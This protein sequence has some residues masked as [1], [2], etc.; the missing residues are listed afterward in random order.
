MISSQGR[1][2]SNFP[3]LATIPDGATLDFVS[4]S[5]NYKIT[6]ANFIT[7]MGATGSLVADGSSTRIDILQASGS[8][9]TIRGLESGNGITVSVGAENGANIAVNMTQEGSFTALVDTFATASPTFASLKGG[10]GISIS[11]AS[12]IITISA[13]GAKPHGLLTMSGNTTATTISVAGTPVLTAGTWTAGSTDN[14]TASTGGRLTYTGAETLDMTIDASITFR[15]ASANEVD[16][17]VTL[18]KN[19]SAASTSKRITS[20]SGS[21]QGSVSMP[22]HIEMAQ[23]DYLELFVSNEDTTDNLTVTSAMFRATR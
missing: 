16:A 1:K 15:S 9:Y 10:T 19:G 5:T 12:N 14:F 13:T 22:Y 2:K 7:Q 18:Y 4:G 23:N 6:K 21:V 17:A 11:K 20:C 8:V 3:V